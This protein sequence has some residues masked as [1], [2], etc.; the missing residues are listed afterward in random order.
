MFFTLISGSPFLFL[1]V[2]PFEKWNLVTYSEL[3]G[4]VIT[5]CGQILVSRT[6]DDLLLPLPSCSPHVR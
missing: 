3:L 2:N 5:L 4:H 1:Y 6:D